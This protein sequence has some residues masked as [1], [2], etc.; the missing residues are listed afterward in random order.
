MPEWKMENAVITGDTIFLPTSVTGNALNNH[1]IGNAE[2]NT[3]RGG[4][5]QDT[6]AGGQGADM[7][8]VDDAGIVI[9]EE[10]DAGEDNVNASVSYVLAGNVDH[11]TLVGTKDINGTGNALNNIMNGNSGNNHLSGGD[12]NDVF[13]GMSGADTLE[14]GNGDDV[15][16]INDKDD[17][18]I[19]GDAG[20]HDTVWVNTLDFDVSKLKNIEVVKFAKDI[21]AAD[22]IKA[23]TGETDI[24]GHDDL[25]SQDAFLFTKKVGKSALAQKITSF[26]VKDDTVYLAKSAFT[27]IAKKG[28]LSKAAFHTGAKAHDANDRVVYDKTKG[29]LYYDAD[30]SGKGAAV[31]F[32]TIDKNLKLSSS[33][34]FVM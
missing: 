27:K 29:V 17:V 21:S 9:V 12:G 3:F 20:G 26:D 13:N 23:L 24:P 11:L 32:A 10:K 5:G 28:V 31:K 18:I 16:F 30:G 8:F 14:G 7:Y 1:L 33:D 4:G 2:A 34:F 6:F 25:P 22:A 19:E 15:F